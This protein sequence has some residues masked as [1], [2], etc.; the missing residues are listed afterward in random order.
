MNT[1]TETIDS[2]NWEETIKDSGFSITEVERFIEES[3][4]RGY[5]ARNKEIR[6][7]IRAIF[8]ANLNQTNQILASLVMY[9]NELG[10]YP[11][12]A[13]L[14][15]DP[16]ANF[17]VILIVKLE[18]Y[19]SA[20]V[21]QAYDWMSDMEK[22]VRNENYN[23]DLSFMDDDANLNHEYLNADGFRFKRNNLNGK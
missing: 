1:I 7:K 22:N 5:L 14:K 23:L 18:D 11:I 2:G 10:I 20:G 13:Y 4:S 16:I 3:Y 6:T 12:T 9:L 19:I 8:N 15:I 21:L 17:S